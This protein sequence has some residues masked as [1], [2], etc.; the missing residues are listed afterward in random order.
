M[1]YIYV[2]KPFSRIISKDEHLRPSVLGWRVIL[3]WILRVMRSEEVGYNEIA[4]D[5]VPLV[6]TNERTGSVK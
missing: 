5:R 1:G 6:N 4:Q 3:R 2:Q